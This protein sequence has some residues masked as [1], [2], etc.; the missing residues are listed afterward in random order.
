MTSRPLPTGQGCRTIVLAGAGGQ[1]KYVSH[2][3]LQKIPERAKNKEKYIKWSSNVWQCRNWTHGVDE[4]VEATFTR[5][6]FDSW[7]VWKELGILYK[8]CG[9]LCGILEQRL[10]YLN[11]RWRSGND[12]SMVIV[13]K[14]LVRNIFIFTADLSH[15]ID[16]HTYIVAH[17]DFRMLST[18]SFLDLH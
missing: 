15:R 2:I 5:A 11:N 10:D 6:I 16:D 8:L 17:S 12:R 9:M 14:L 7:R 3:R 18:S 4:I 13:T 1:H